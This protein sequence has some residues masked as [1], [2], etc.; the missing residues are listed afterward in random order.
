MSFRNRLRLF[1]GLIVIVPM[2][3]LG[4]VLFALT[5][6][7]ETGKAD[8]GIVAGGR[9]AVGLYREQIDRARPAVRRLARDRALHRAI[10][11]GNRA[12]TARRLRELVAGPVHAAELWTPGGER[13][14]RVT[15]GPALAPAASAIVVGGGSRVVLSVSVTDATD[16]AYRL[17]GLTG[18]EVVIVRGE[19][20]LASTRPDPARPA[21]LPGDGGRTTRDHGGEE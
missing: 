15:A 20:P 10:E 1:F 9:A 11:S 16:F 19:R 7:S 14:A 12:D 5:A 4:A 17:K 8:A 21:R 13:L 18:L 6:R 3:A 2:V